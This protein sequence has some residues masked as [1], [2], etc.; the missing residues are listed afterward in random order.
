MHLTEISGNAWRSPPLA[1]P[2]SSESSDSTN[3]SIV[4]GGRKQGLTSRAARSLSSGYAEHLEN[5]AE[6]LRAQAHSPQTGAPFKAKFEAAK[7]ENNK[8]KDIIQDLEDAF[9]AKVK[10]AVEHMSTVEVDLRRRIRNLEDELEQKSSIITELEYEKSEARVDVTV[11]DSLKA[12]IEKLEA[13][14]RSLEDANRSIGKRNEVLTELLAVSPTKLQQGVDLFSP[15]RDV[16]RRRARPQSMLIPRLPSSPGLRYS[17]RPQSLVGSPA[18]S[19]HCYSSHMILAEEMESAEGVREGEVRQNPIDLQSVDSGLGESCSTKSADMGSSRRSTIVS[20]GSISPSSWGLPLPTSP[21]KDDA[22]I[23]APSRRKPRRF[24]TGSTQLKP[25]L[26]PSLAGEGTGGQ[27][28]MMSAPPSPVKRQVSEESLDP[29]ILFLSKVPDSPTPSSESTPTWL[30]GEPSS[31][32]DYNSYDSGRIAFSDSPEPDFREPSLADDAIKTSFQFPINLGSFSPTEEQA[33]ED[34]DTIVLEHSQSEETT[35]AGSSGD[36]FDILENSLNSRKL[37]RAADSES[38]SSATPITRDSCG[39]TG[40]GFQL[41]D[42]Q[43]QVRIPGLQYGDAPN[44]SIQSECEENDNH[45]SAAFSASPTSNARKRRK[46]NWDCDHEIHHTDDTMSGSNITV[47]HLFERKALVPRSKT[48][49]GASSRRVSKLYGLQGRSCPESQLSN[50]SPSPLEVL[51]RRKKN[52][53][54]LAAITIRTIYGTLSRYTTYMR[55]IKRDPTALARRVIANAWHTNWKVLGQLSWWVLGLFLG[56]GPRNRAQS[57][58]WDDYDAL[59]IA[60]RIQAEEEGGGSKRRS[61]NCN[62]HP[63]QQRRVRF[64]ETVDGYRTNGTKS[65]ARQ[66]LKGAKQ[67]VSWGESL[68]L[69]GKFSFAILLAVGGAVVKGPAEML[70]DCDK[71]TTSTTSRSSMQPSTNCQSESFSAALPERAMPTFDFDMNFK[72]TTGDINSANG[73]QWHSP[74]LPS[75]RDKRSR[76]EPKRKTSGSWT[77]IC[78]PETH[79]S[80]PGTLSRIF[81]FDS[82]FLPCGDCHLTYRDPPD[83]AD[84]HDTDNIKQREQLRLKDSIDD[85]GGGEPELYDPASPDLPPNWK[86]GHHFPLSKELDVLVNNKTA[87]QPILDAPI[88]S[89]ATQPSHY[90]IDEET[91]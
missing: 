32:L 9:D 28:S 4:K 75:H 61:E 51:Q 50:R 57:W 65:P 77:G 45:R 90:T 3:N 73:A 43:S 53:L 7:L 24:L 70:K 47:D 34:E 41:S 31:P 23:K 68:Y 78:F 85:P 56:P 12:T 19:P 74:Q 81:N 87:S 89:E 84:G 54:P 20:Q 64:N 69:W 72:D 42:E 17:S 71:R 1:Y 10:E 80:L 37:N 35:M 27:N 86:D 33:D 58:D 46:A 22:T 66:A 44:T 91:G 76:L 60:E 36:G 5:L 38:K 55:Q 16:G 48:N 29:T 13:E 40:L 15:K 83:L 59:S 52:Q 14:N 82:Q 63:Q 21:L 26:L 25:L 49:H 2:T 6:S 39:S 62:E 67:K 11:I 30:E 8:L 88:T 79:A 18:T